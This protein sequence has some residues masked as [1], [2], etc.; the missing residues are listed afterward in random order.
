M[1]NV[2]AFSGWVVLLTLVLALYGQ[3]YVGG[4]VECSNFA[5]TQVS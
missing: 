3:F 4:K 1:T 2:G 5:N